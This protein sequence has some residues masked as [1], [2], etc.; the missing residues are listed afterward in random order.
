MLI[1]VAYVG[2]RAD[3]LLLLANFNQA[4][5]NNAA[6]TIP[7]QS[8]RPIADFGDITYVFNGGK[9][10]YK[11][12]QFKYEW[13]PNRDLT[14]FNSLTLSEAK[15][16]AA[17]SLENQN[18][19]FPV[20]AGSSKSRRRLRL[21]GLSP[22]LQPDDEFCVVF[23]GWQ[24]QAVRRQHVVRARRDCRR[25]AARRGQTLSRQEKWSRSST[26]RRRTS[27]SPRSPTTSGVRITTG[28]TSAAIRTPRK[29]SSR[30]PAGSIPRVYRCRPIRASRSGTRRATTCEDR[31]SRSSIWRRS[32]R[33]NV[34]G[35]SR[36]E[37]RLEVFN[38][39]NRVNFTAPASN[40]SVATFGTITG[41]YPA[42]QVQ[43]GLKFLW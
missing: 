18:G 30:L 24:G 15:D 11:A 43:L 35:E 14:L 22:A 42:R 34:A 7:L 39:F 41:A 31:I 27:R 3:D 8:R 36:A 4:A 20:P 10:R 25:V 28:R 17:G 13:R 5:P 23:A 19:N 26:A 16:N 37:L 38:L 40:R 32:S 6:G 9:S 21:V 2:N 1:D 29:T 12:L 33:S